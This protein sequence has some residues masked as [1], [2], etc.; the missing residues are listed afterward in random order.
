MK[1]NQHEQLFTELTPEEAA[2]IEGGKR[3]ILH[4][5]KCVR[6]NMD[7]PAS[8]NSDDVYIKIGGQTVWG[9]KSMDDGHIIELNDIG[10]NFSNSINVSL[11]D[12]DGIFGD[13]EIDNKNFSAITNGWKSASFTNSNG[14]SYR[15][16]YKVT[17]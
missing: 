11:W 14:S 12:D 4:K 1:D 13:D 10:R 16:T 9:P 15:L 7:T 6:A 2:V 17:A 3:I 5:I 8:L